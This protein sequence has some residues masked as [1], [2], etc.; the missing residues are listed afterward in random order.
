MNPESL[1]YGSLK[2]ALFQAGRCALGVIALS[3]FW[4]VPF[5]ASGRSLTQTGR[6]MLSWGINGDPL[7]SSSVPSLCNPLSLPPPC[8]P[9]T[10]VCEIQLFWFPHT[11]RNI[12]SVLGDC[13]APLGFPLHVVQTGC[14]LWSVR[15]GQCLSSP[16]LFSI[17]QGLP[18]TF[19]W[20]LVLRTIASYR[21][22]QAWGWV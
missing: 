11:P 8:H 16:H 13:G 10:P 7:P 17:T 15:V 18:F 9:H 12:S 2:R 21:L 4:L 14:S 3:D 20:L 19:W 1:P 5:L 6:G 22:F